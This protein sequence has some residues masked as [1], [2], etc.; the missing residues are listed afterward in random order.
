MSGVL[1][2]AAESDWRRPDPQDLLYL[3]LDAGL[4]VF[5]LAPEFAPRTI[6]NMRKLVS[7]GFFDG[8][9]IVRSQENYVV[10]WG[11]PN[12]ATGSARTYGSAAATIEPEFFRDREGLQLT[13]LDTQDAYADEVGFADGFPVGSD[14]ERAWLAHCYGM[15]GVGRAN[16]PDSGNGAELYA[17]I[18]HAPRHLDR[19]VALVGRAVYGMEHLSTLPRGKGALGFYESDLENVPVRSMRFGD[20]MLAEERLDMLVLRTDTETFRQLVEARRNRV[21]GWFV[22]PGGRVGLCNVP[23]PVRLEK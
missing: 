16:E 1:Q 21:E 7:Q 3:K 15:L 12:A 4:V 5:E 14:G 20:E 8:L 18:G 23:L 17:V 11:D 19:N 9:A 13:L 10:Q 6:D 2:D 22:D